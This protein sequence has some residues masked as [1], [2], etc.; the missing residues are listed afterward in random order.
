MRNF[1]K[2]GA[3]LSL[4]VALVLLVVAG[5]S[6]KPAGTEVSA[7]P[8]DSSTTIRV[9][10]P[11]GQ[12]GPFYE[13]KALFEQANPEIKIDETTENIA[14]LTRKI[15]DGMEHPEVFMSMGDREVDLLE[16]KGRVIPG[17]R[18]AYARNS[19]A[20]ITSTANPAG[21]KTIKDAA[22]PAVKAFAIVDPENSSAGFHARQAMEKLGVWS[23]VSQKTRIPDQPEMVAQL[24]AK[25]DAQAG[26]AYWPCMVETHDPKATGPTPRKKVTVAQVIPQDLYTPFSCTAAVIQG[27]GNP[28][29]GKKF[30]AFLQ[31]PEA[32]QIFAK[33]NFVDPEKYS[34]AN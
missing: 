7:P 27:A 32:Q 23:S 2:L 8:T 22:R 9:L 18:T 4:L 30:I 14:V 26:I 29:L 31:S 34:K 12:M 24:V 19:L 33:W 5:C 25:G 16:A 11:C 3:M 1:F 17:T 20:L 13:I 15:L 10:V 6:Q 28:E 21:V